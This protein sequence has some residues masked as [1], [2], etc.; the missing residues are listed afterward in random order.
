[1]LLPGL[2]EIEAPAMVRVGLAVGVSVLLY[3]H[4]APAI[5]SVPD[6]LAALRD[7]VAFYPG[8]V[9]G[10]WLDGEAVQA[11]DGD[12]YGGWITSAVSGP[13]KGPPG[14]LGW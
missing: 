14:T 4:V 11:Q 6:G 7:H 2:G 12:F 5:A 8:R 10:A 1:M 3:P 9:D 13:F